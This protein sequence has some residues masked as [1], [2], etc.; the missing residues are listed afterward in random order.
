MSELFFVTNADMRTLKAR[1][2]EIPELVED[3]AITITRQDHIGSGVAGINDGADEQPLPINLEASEVADDLRGTIVGWVNHTCQSR[4][5]AYPGGPSTPALAIWLARHVTSLAMT[6]GCEEALDE[7]TH[8][9]SRARRACDPIRERRERTAAEV[10][11][12]HMRAPA[13]RVTP[14]Q[15]EALMPELGYPTL[16]AATVRQWRKRGKVEA[17][18][19][20]RYLLGD[21]MAL[22]A[23]RVDLTGVTH[24]E[25]G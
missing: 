24:G 8:A 3:L 5:I 7:I 1:L 4:G 10:L 17:D 21:L 25:V 13:L 20:G 9:M 16:R 11:E 14:M 6:E 15:A 22:C 23:Q 18:A 19:G 12:A 2:E